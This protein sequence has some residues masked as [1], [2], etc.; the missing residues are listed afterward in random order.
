MCLTVIW[1][2]KIEIAQ[3]DIK[4][5]KFV[6]KHWNHW[7]PR[8]R[9]EHIRF[10]YCKLITALDK[11]L[12]PIEKLT[13]CHYPQKEI[14]EGFHSRVT[15][16]DCIANTVCI[17]PKGSEFCYGDDDDIVSTQLIVFKN[18]FQYLMYKL[19]KIL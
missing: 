17:I 12:K 14:F 4:V 8:Y 5:Y 19:K 7:N 10:K 16:R 1:G 9:Q 13:I 18:R 6:K 2:S 11:D 3:K 15:N